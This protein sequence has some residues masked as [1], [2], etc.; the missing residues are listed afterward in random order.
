M[1]WLSPKVED[2]RNGIHVVVGKFL[3]FYYFIILNYF[4][5]FGDGVGC[6]WHFALF[7]WKGGSWEGGLFVSHT[8]LQPKY[9]FI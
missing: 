7:R 6:W 8:Q 9:I 2:L 5:I 4:I 3:L 1:Q